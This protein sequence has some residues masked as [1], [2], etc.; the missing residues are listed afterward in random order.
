MLLLLQNIIEEVLYIP[1]Y[2]LEAAETFINLFFAGIESV[3]LAA[4][5]LIPL[6]EVPAPP[7]FVSAINWF[8]PIGAVISVATP[9]VAG[10]VVFISVRWIYKWVGAL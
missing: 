2:I 9:I 10:Y 1:A 4:T 6:P 8:F 3:W 7:E 5:S